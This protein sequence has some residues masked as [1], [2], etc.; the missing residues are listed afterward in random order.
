MLRGADQTREE[1]PIKRAVAALARGKG[2]RLRRRAG[3]ILH[4]DG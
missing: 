4:T 3:K 2:T 1:R